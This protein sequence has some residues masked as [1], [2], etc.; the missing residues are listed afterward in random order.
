MSTEQILVVIFG[1]GVSVFT[2]IILWL[3]KNQLEKVK[4]LE[5]DVQALSQEIAAMNAKQDSI[6][7]E[8]KDLKLDIINI[9]ANRRDDIKGVHQR[10]DKIIENM[11]PKK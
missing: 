5:H 10:L 7:L 3:F 11:R 6:F 8:L 1:G 4:E 2:G 9:D